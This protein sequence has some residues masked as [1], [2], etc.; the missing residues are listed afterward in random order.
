MNEGLVQYLGGVF[1][2]CWCK[3]TLEFV[4]SFLYWPIRLFRAGIAQIRAENRLA[5]LFRNKTCISERYRW[6][7]RGFWRLLLL[8]LF[9]ILLFAEVN[10]NDIKAIAMVEDAK[11]EAVVGEDGPLL[12]RTGTDGHGTGRVA[13][14]SGPRLQ[15]NPDSGPVR[16]FKGGIP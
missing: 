4:W 16:Y 5:D 14:R 3:H 9:F 1:D 12:Q 7:P 11:A 6:N 8:C 13:C 10:V 15:L 2:W